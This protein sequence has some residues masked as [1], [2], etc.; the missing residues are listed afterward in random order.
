MIFLSGG[1]TLKGF[2][3]AASVPSVAWSS[4][5]NLPNPYTQDAGSGSS[6]TAALHF[7]GRESGSGSTGKTQTYDGSTFTEVNDFDRDSA[8]STQ[9]INESTGYFGT[10]VSEG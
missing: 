1:T 7:G 4:G 2:G 10:K 8:E 5:T 6:N 9:K 3:K